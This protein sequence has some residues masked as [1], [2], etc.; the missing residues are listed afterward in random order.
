MLTPV[1][2]VRV[3]LFYTVITHFFHFPP[4]TSDPPLIKLTP[5][6]GIPLQNQN[7][8]TLSNRFFSKIFDRPFS[9]VGGGACHGWVVLLIT[10]GIY[11]PA[12]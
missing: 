10:F 3:V 2:R 9:R 8:L 1:K 11:F 6:T 7:F 12:W 4:K 5:I